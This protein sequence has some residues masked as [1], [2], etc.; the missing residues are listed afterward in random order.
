SSGINAEY[1]PWPNSS[2]TPCR[3]RCRRSW[4]TCRSASRSATT[5]WPSWKRWLPNS[6]RVATRA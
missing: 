5:N 2:T 6:N 4:P 1:L 3:G